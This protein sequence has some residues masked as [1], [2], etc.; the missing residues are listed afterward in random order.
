[1]SEHVDRF[2]AFADE[3]MPPQIAEVLHKTEAPSS[4]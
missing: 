1:M 3:H 4:R 2:L